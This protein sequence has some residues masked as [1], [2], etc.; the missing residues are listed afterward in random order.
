MSKITVHRAPH[1]RMHGM[2]YP[3]FHTGRKQLLPSSLKSM[4]I[5]KST[6]IKRKPTVIPAIKIAGSVCG[7]SF[8]SV[9]CLGLISRVCCLR[10]PK[11]AAKLAK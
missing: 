11:A 10:F 6:L 8:D 2:I 5:K 7:F 1:G 4:Y 9:D 3:M